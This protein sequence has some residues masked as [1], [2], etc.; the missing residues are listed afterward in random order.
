MATNNAHGGFP[1][2]PNPEK[3]HAS[4]HGIFTPMVSFV[5]DHRSTRFVSSRQIH[6]GRRYLNMF[7]FSPLAART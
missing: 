1:R 6:T 7:N 3:V 2:P 5:Y 4:W